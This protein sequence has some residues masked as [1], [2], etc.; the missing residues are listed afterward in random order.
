MFIFIILYPCIITLNIHSHNCHL[1]T[2]ALLNIC[3]EVI[4][5]PGTT[6]SEPTTSRTIPS[7]LTTQGNH[8]RTTISEPYHLTRHIFF[9]VVFNKYCRFITLTLHHVITSSLQIRTNS[10]LIL[11]RVNC[12]INVA[13]SES[14]WFV[15]SA[16]YTVGLLWNLIAL[17]Q[18]QCFMLLYDAAFRI[19]EC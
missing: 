18:S 14:L 12:T 6:T 7:E 10:D 13:R 3:D 5:H 17:L 11:N 2:V 8:S 1:I 9:R 4:I 16:M 19:C 15:A